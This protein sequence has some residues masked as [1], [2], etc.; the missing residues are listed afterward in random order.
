MGVSLPLLAAAVLSAAALGAPPPHPVLEQ[1]AAALADRPGLV[2]WLGAGD[3]ALAVE[4]AKSADCRLHGIETDPAAAEAAG[5]AILKA[6]L[7]GRAWVE[8]LPSLDPLPYNN[9]LANLVVIDN[10]TRAREAGLDP[11]EVRRVLAPLGVVVAGQDARHGK[12]ADADAIRKWLAAEG[13]G[14][15]RSIARDGAWQVFRK[16]PRPGMDEFSHKWKDP[17][18][19]LGTDDAGIAIPN[20]VRWM[21]VNAANGGEYRTAGGRVFL[22]ATKVPPGAEREVELTSFDASSGVRQWSSVFPA[23]R[24]KVPWVAAAGRVILPAGDQLISIDA[25]TG[26]QRLVYDQAGAPEDILVQ[27]GVL[28]CTDPYEVRALDV[29]SGNVLW[30]FASQSPRPEKLSPRKGGGLGGYIQKART[31][32]FETYC[33]VAAE[34]K[35]FLLEYFVAA[36]QKPRAKLLGLN[37]KT[38]KVEWSSDDPLLAG[39]YRKCAYYAGQLIVS[40]PGALLGLPVSGGGRRWQH[41][42][43]SWNP[44]AGKVTLDI[45]Q[46]K[47]VFAAAGL[48]WFRNSETSRG[49]TV[50][51]DPPDKAQP[52]KT[53]IGLDPR[54]GEERT[55]IGYEIADGVWQQRCYPDSATPNFIYS[56]NSEFINTKDRDF[57]SWRVMRGICG[58]GPVY[59]SGTMYIPPAFCYWCYPMVRGGLALDTAP[60]RRIPVKDDERL[61]RGPA[62][63]APGPPPKVEPQ[64]WPMFRHDMKRTGG[65]PAAA[66]WPLVPAKGWPKAFGTRIHAPLVVGDTL[67]VTCIN[68]GRILAMDADGRERWQY[69]A[70]SRID[71]PPTLYGPLLLFG[72]HDGKVH[73]I[74]AADGVLAWRLSVAP[75]VRRM[76][77]TDVVESPWPVMGSVLVVEGVAYVSAG[78]ITGLDGGL[79][80][81]ALDAA[82]G[83]VKWLRIVGPSY[84]EPRLRTGADNNPA[85]Y[86]KKPLGPTE[87]QMTNGVLVYAGGDELRLYDQQFVW[88]FNR[89]DGSFLLVESGTGYPHSDYSAGLPW[90]GF[91][92]VSLAGMQAGM[93]IHGEFLIR[94][95]MVVAFPEPTAGGLAFGS[96]QKTGYVLMGC[97]PEGVRWVREY[98]N[99]EGGIAPAWGPITYDLLADAALAAGDKGF[100]VGRPM[101]RPPAWT[102]ATPPPASYN[103]KTV[104]MQIDPAAGPQLRCLALAEGKELGRMPL[105]APALREGAMTFGRGRLYV[106]LEDGQ[107]LCLQG[108]R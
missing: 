2:V 46:G 85:G 21:T 44:T 34:G 35:A 38:G 97:R 53:W 86:W 39:G 52:F 72:C 90:H 75:E 16:P 50:I 70:G 92:R 62:Y 9:S 20:T 24:S 6:G 47:S 26:R 31:T 96:A 45:G 23:G 74:R 8:A 84:H 36:D 12:E 77:A 68:Q 83:A 27:D 69:A 49:R 13:L 93:T 57:T 17:T 63:G 103:Q 88:R 42:A 98:E 82:T 37:L 108:A 56:S 60:P 54:T 79:R 22:L 5:R 71:L 58:E 15:V 7:C 51:I 19:N 1:A 43:R 102:T 76:V 80:L 87:G 78:R 106:A 64:D 3:G 14:P 94:G 66:D 89:K 65:T 11:A 61:E 41:E 100:L 55:R 104:P 30:T 95:G 10:L 91:G 105:P 18:R 25:A 67:Y 48:V 99:K 29:E 59:G 33:V 28:V 101:T 81:C 32:G 107:L 4:L 73:A 40:T